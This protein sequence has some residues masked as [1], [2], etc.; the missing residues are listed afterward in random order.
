[1]PVKTTGAE[2]KR[3]Y[4]DPEFWKEEMFH[5]GEVI[6]IDGVEQ[7][8]YSV[9]YNELGDDVRLEVS[10]GI[11]YADAQASEEVGSMEGYFRKWR[12]KQTTDVF[13]V[14]A[15]KEKLDAIKA[16]VKAAGGKVLKA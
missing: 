12:R 7:E 2:F 6:A 13:L 14:E 16:A 9:D 5:E 10:H 3:F 8:E 15:P 11:V 4:N 1:M